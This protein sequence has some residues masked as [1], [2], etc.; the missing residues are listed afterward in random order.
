MQAVLSRVISSRVLILRA[1]CISCW[2]STT[3]MPSAC[4]ANSTGGSTASTP[5]GSP[6]RPR[7]SSS[8]RILRATS[9]A[10]S[11]S[12]TSSRAWSRCRRASA[13]LL[14]RVSRAGVARRRAEVPHD[15]LLV[16]GQQA[17]APQLVSAQVPMCV[18]VI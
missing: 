2:P 11:D 7:S 3:W 12:G 15:R 14:A 1:S 5:S 9:S 17:E 4:S 8:T 10:R 13:L 16:L 6:S 18:A